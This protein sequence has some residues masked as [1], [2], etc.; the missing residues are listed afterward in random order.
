MSRK[1]KLTVQGDVRIRARLRNLLSIVEHE[2]EKSLV[3][4]AGQIID[5]SR[6]RVPVDTGFLYRSAF[7]NRPTKRSGRLDIVFGYDAKYASVVH[8]KY[9]GFRG[10]RFYLV[11]AAME[12]APELPARIVRNNTRGLAMGLRSGR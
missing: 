3:E 7:I 1:T 10:E 12:I 4:I 2:T 6:T 9:Q 11:S 5:L 8:E